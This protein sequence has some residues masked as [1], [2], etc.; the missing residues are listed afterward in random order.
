[1]LLRTHCPSWKCS[2]LSGYSPGQELQCNKPVSAE[3]H[4]TTRSYRKVSLSTKQQMTQLPAVRLCRETGTQDA[5]DQGPE[6]LPCFCNQCSNQEI[7]GQNQSLLAG[8]QPLGR[9]RVPSSL[10]FKRRKPA[11]EKLFNPVHLCFK[12]ST[13]SFYLCKENSVAF[14]TCRRTRPKT[15]SKIRPSNIWISRHLTHMGSRRRG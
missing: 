5:L 4:S 9:G 11:T 15:R 2:S 12:R 14:S 3:A 8:N 13:I 10:C 1:M 6:L 7:K